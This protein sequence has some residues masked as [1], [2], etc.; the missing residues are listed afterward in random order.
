[1]PRQLAA[2]APEPV[3]PTANGSGSGRTDKEVLGKELEEQLKLTLDVR[4]SISRLSQ[5][6]E[7]M[8]AVKRQ[9]EARNELLKDDAKAEALVKASKEFVTKLDALEEKLHNPKAKVV[10]DVLAQKGGAKL[11]SQLVWLFEQL[12][13]ADGP[14]TQGVKEQYQEQAELL[15]K[16]EEE[17][18]AL[19]SGDLARL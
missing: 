13:D 12:K 9:L 8:R 2:F 1:D 6:V 15:R 18:K 19:Q 7:Q 3:R 17:W 16:Y 14:P 10:Y 4:D 5:T 11:Y